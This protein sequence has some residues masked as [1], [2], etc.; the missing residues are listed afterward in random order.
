M[1]RRHGFTGETIALI[2]PVS[3]PVCRV[4]IVRQARTDVLEIR[5]AHARPVPDHLPH[6]A[7][8]PCQLGAHSVRIP[9][10]DVPAL[11]DALDKALLIARQTDDA[12]A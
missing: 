12:A 1:R 6:V 9:L 4:A 11:R 8:N 2:G 10:A 5:S 3:F 7:N